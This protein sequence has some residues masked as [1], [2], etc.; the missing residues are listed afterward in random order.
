MRRRLVLTALLAAVAAPALAAADPVGVWTLD[1]QAWDAFVAG[2]APKIIAKMPKAQ[3]EALEAR[4]V[5]V[6]AEIR[7]GLSQG[8]EGSIELRPNGRVVAQNRYGEPDGTGLWRNDGTLIEIDLPAERLLLQ[9]T[10][11]GDRME[12]KP[13]LD[14]AMTGKAADPLWAEAVRQVTFVLVRKG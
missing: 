13:V 11:R 5:D 9:G 12:L 2:L 4:G 8:I 14:P 3:R 10:W 1:R 6:A 7:A